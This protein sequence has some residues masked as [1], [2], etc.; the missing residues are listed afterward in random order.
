M[1][2]RHSFVVKNTP[3]FVPYEIK[4]QARNHQGW[5]PEPRV[6]SGYSGEDCEYSPLQVPSRTAGQNC[7]STVTP[8]TVSHLPSYI[9]TL[10]AKVSTRTDSCP[11]CSVC[12]IK[13]LRMSN[14]P[15][16]DSPSPCVPLTFD[17]SFT[18]HLFSAMH[19]TTIRLLP[20]RTSGSFWSEAKSCLRKGEICFFRP[21][22]FAESVSQSS[23]KV[24]QPNMLLSAA[25]K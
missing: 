9:K 1:V 6:V 15:P 24:I 8:R 14:P 25:A 3:T 4:I 2:K 23:R 13:S 18:I 17:L 21:A 10:L 5:G 20:S 19:V 7:I 11:E 16:L 12:P 22:S